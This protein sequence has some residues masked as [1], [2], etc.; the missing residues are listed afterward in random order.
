LAQ[1]TIEKSTYGVYKPT[2][3]KF[4]DSFAV[5]FSSLWLQDICAKYEDEGTAIHKRLSDAA[6]MKDN[7]TAAKSLMNITSSF[8]GSM[9]IGARTENVS[10]SEDYIGEFNVTELIEI[11]KEERSESSSES[12]DWLFCPCPIPSSIYQWFCQDPTYRVRWL[13]V[14]PYPYKDHWLYI[15]P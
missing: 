12:S 1:K 7:T 2:Y 8:N 3:F 13:S 10:I 9:H 6:L 15:H 11:V 5:N 4:A 14:C